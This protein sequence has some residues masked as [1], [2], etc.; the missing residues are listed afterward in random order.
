MVKHTVLGLCFATLFTSGMAQNNINAPAASPTIVNAGDVYNPF[1]HK[2]SRLYNGIEHLG[3][4]ARI[5]GHAYFLQRELQTGTLVYDELEFVKLQARE[6][7]WTLLT[8]EGQVAIVSGY[9]FINRLGY[10]VCR[11]PVESDALIEV[12]LG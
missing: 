5:K 6:M 2:Q 11:K 12:R 8:V 9:H 4:S 1:I 7:I 10:F 3:Y